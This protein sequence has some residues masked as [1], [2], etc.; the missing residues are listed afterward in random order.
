MNAADWHTQAQEEEGE[1][2]SV[3]PGFTVQAL[4]QGSLGQAGLAHQT[5]VA[6]EKGT[7]E[8]TKPS[9]VWLVP[10]PSILASGLPCQSLF[11]FVTNAKWL[12]KKKSEERKD[13]LC[14]YVQPIF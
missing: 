13:L 12:R 8:D 2:G 6:A 11:S 7:V 4:R 5:P 3:Q 10:S 14:S 1:V 9:T